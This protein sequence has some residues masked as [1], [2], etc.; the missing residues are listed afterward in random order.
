LFCSN[1]ERAKLL[2]RNFKKISGYGL[3][4]PQLIDI[5]KKS[6]DKE[7]V[8]VEPITEDLIGKKN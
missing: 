3:K 7:A 2:M 8:E 4:S 5:I 6:E 1:E